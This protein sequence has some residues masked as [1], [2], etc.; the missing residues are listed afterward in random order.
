VRSPF[1][2]PSLYD[3]GRPCAGL[4]TTRDL[5]GNGHGNRSAFLDSFGDAR[6][7]AVEQ[8]LAEFRAA[9]DTVI[10]ALPVEGLTGEVVSLFQQQHRRARL[11]VPTQ[12]VKPAGQWQASLAVVRLL[13]LCSK[14]WRP[15]SDRQ[16]IPQPAPMWQNLRY[17]VRRKRPP[18]LVL[19]TLSHSFAGCRGRGLSAHITLATFGEWHRPF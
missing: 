2:G 6:Q 17:P 8:A 15:T 16:E 4:V 7:I 12:K 18:A 19:A 11:I 3:G 1:V 10:P 9:G 14:Q 13:H 5:T